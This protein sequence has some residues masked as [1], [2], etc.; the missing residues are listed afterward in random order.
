M[1]TLAQAAYHRALS[2]IQERVRTAQVRAATAAQHELVLLYWDIGHEITRLQSEHGWG[3]KVIDQ[4][5]RDLRAALPDGK[6]FSIRNL[7]Y[8]RA[9][10]DAWPDRAIVQQVV[11]Q[12]PWS[13]QVILLDKPGSADHQG[14]LSLRLPLPRAR[15]TRAQPGARLAASH[16]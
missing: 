5:S 6:G 8:M 7:K 3:A 2:S 4:L 15:C 10:A 9:F 12:L 14:S 11:A 16:P 13:H 1:S